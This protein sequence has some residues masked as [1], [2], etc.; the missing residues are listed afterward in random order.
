[1]FRASGSVTVLGL[2]SPA[3]PAGLPLSSVLASGMLG[4]AFP[5]RTVQGGGLSFFLLALRCPSEVVLKLG[6]CCASEQAARRALPIPPL[7]R[8]VSPAGLGF[9][10]FEMFICRGQRARGGGGPRGPHA[11]KSCPWP[12]ADSFTRCVYY[13][14]AGP[15][16]LYFCK[17]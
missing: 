4:P 7:P 12:V 16:K 8:V 1:M 10:V 13:Y 9:A 17:P 6:T 11:W 3:G 15:Q 5:S 2:A 14:P